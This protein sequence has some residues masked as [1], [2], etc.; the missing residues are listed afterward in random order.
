MLETKP[1]EISMRILDILAPLGKGKR[2][3]SAP[4]AGKINNIEA[5]YQQCGGKSP[6]IELVSFLWMNG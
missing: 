5:D 6:E 1:D 3:D 4:K 2:I